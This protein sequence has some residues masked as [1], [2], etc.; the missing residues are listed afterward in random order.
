MTIAPLHALQTDLTIEQL[1]HLRRTPQLSA[2]D[3]QALATAKNQRAL[4]SLNIPVPQSIT[5]KANRKRLQPMVQLHLQAAQ[6]AGHSV[7]RLSSTPAPS[8]PAMQLMFAYG[9]MPLV[10]SGDSVKT[11]THYQEGVLYTQ[12]RHTAFEKRAEDTLEKYGAQRIISDQASPQVSLL[13]DSQWVLPDI[14]AWQSFLTMSIPQ[15]E[16]QSWQIIVHNDFEL[17]FVDIEDEDAWY[18]NIEESDNDWFDVGL[19]VQV[20][21]QSVNLLPILLQALHGQRLSDQI[22]AMRANPDAMLPVPIEEGSHRYINLPVKRL[23]PV[24]ETFIELFDSETQLDDDGRLRLSRLDT[25]RL[26]LISGTD[27]HWQGG[28]KLRR[29]AQRLASFDGLKSV[30]VPS[31]FHGELRPYQQQGLDW[32]QF[33]RDFELAGILADDMGLGKTVQALA[34]ICCE[35]RGRRLN[36]PCLIIAPTSLVGNWKNEAQRFAPKLKVLPLQGADRKQHF[37][38]ISQQDIVV[39]TYPLLMRDG[40]QLAQHDYHMLILDE[41][42]NIKNP[43]SKAAQWVRTCHTKHRLCLTGTPMENHL[44]ELWALYDFL[45]PGMLGDHKTFTRLYRK[46]IE[47]Q[48]DTARHAALSKR[49]KPF[50]LRREKQSV[51]KELPDKTE[52]VRTVALSGK[53]RDLYE[54]IRLSMHQKVQSAIATKGLARSHIM[55]LEALLKLRQVCCHP[56]LLKLS[57]AKK[58]KM[59]AKLELLMDMLP[60]MVEEGRKILLFSQFTSMLAVIEEKLEDVNINYV[61]LTGQ[62]RKRQTVIDQFQK[63][64]VPVF[65]ISLKA[66]GVGLNLTAA[67]TVIHYDPWWNPAVEDQATD[68]SYRIGQDKPVF[69]YKLMTEQT[70]EEKILAMQTRKRA[71]AEG[72][73]QPH[74]GVER[75]DMSA[76]DIEELFKPLNQ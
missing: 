23:I 55:I 75:F 38:K 57:S 40:E 69:V 58:I 66:G 18:A 29:L 3:S 24:L 10:N 30:S 4:N 51:A 19:G 71:L 20:E 49:L 36:K 59:S 41:A 46:P 64:D 35:K 44:G 73:Y 33:L 1:E 26:T 63:D 76:T 68:R 65:L 22:T 53:Q 43:R 27:W 60:E 70:I 17:E 37:D 13:M 12:V 6:Q 52:I 8:I 31:T 45:M 7:Q 50:M 67:D 5:V 25:S 47:Q 56:P 34:H 16:Q 54:T 72:T 14:P 32:L 11:I 42:Q 39:S 2:K 62:T 9:D 15:L 74:G 48:G 28:K 21:G 61:K